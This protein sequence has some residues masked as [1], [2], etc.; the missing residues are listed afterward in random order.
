M[1]RG[2]SFLRVIG[3]R[4]I[5]IATIVTFSMSDST[6]AQ[7]EPPGVLQD[8]VLMRADSVTYDEDFGII[9]ASGHVEISHGENI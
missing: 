4:I 9:T 5:A 8:D 2:T 6:W 1:D 7:S 3:H